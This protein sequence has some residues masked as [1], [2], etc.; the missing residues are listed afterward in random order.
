M[1]EQKSTRQGYGKALLELGKNKKVIALCADLNESTQVTHFAQKYP[2]RFFQCG[3]AEQNMISMAA[4]FALEGFIPFASSFG[5]FLPMRC[6]DQIRMSVCYNKANVKLVA[7]HCGLSTGADGA[8]H[9]ALE[10]V[11]ALRSL[12]GMTIIEPGDYEQAVQATRAIAKHKGPVYLRLHRTKSLP[13]PKCSF[14]IG[15]AQLLQKGTKVTVIGSGPILNEVLNAKLNFKPEIIN[16]HTI[17]PL[18]TKTIL[19]SVTKTNKVLVVQ[20]HQ[21][22]GGLCSA[23]AELLS[24]QHPCKVDFV[25]VSDTFGESGQPGELWDKYGLSATHISQKILKLCKK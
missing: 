17:K 3:V 2:S 11:A 15:K 13:L 9:Q 25:G 12:P 4:G 22:S 10:D 19:R 7:T 1:V 6:L 8:S 5:V 21:V 16:C 18:D 24:V 20:D 14:K 23:I